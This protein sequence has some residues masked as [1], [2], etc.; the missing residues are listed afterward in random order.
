MGQGVAEEE[1]EEEEDHGRI[2]SSSCVPCQASSASDSWIPSAAM[3]KAVALA[4]IPS[5]T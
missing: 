4:S 1:V 2:F 5:G 3:A